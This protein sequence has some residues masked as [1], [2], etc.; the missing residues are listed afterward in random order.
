[1]YKFESSI[2]YIVLLEEQ[3]CVKGVVN[4]LCVSLDGME[5]GYGYLRQ[6]S[7]VLRCRWR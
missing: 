7:L 4:G 2:I 1:M 6:G 5:S 3:I